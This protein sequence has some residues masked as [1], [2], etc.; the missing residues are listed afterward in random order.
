MYNVG[1]V[2]AGFVG[3]RRAEVAKAHPNTEVVLVYD[4]QEEAAVAVVGACGGGV[5]DSWE[6]LVTT[7][8]DIVVVATTH[9]ALAEISTAALKAGRHVLCEKPMGRNPGEGR[10]AVEMAAESGKVLK[11]GYTTATTRRCRRSTRYATLARL[12][13]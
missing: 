8:I 9:D 10:M 2:G 13:R 12:A 7:D 3:M 4:M 1:I 6:A 5:A 11:V